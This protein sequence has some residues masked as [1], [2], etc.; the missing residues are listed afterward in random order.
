[1]LVHSGIVYPSERDPSHLFA[2][3]RSLRD[4]GRINAD[5]LLLRFRAPGHEYHVREL[6]VR[7]GVMD[8]IEIAPPL[9]YREALL[10][11]TSAD[12]LVVLQAANCDQQIP[13]KLYEYLR[14]GRA[15]LGLATGDTANVLLAAGVPY[16]AALDDAKVI[17]AVIERFVADLE[18]GRVSL[19]NPDFVRGASRRERTQE[20]A[21]L[22]DRA[23]AP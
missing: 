15:I 3:L 6:A 5:T 4:A 17:A 11:M 1:M 8:L 9:P 22:L 20:L 16:V 12:G 13:A 19:P 2:A 7:F 14:A 18:S 10:E 21:L 23:I